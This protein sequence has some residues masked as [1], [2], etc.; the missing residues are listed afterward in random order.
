M[1]VAGLVEYRYEL[2]RGTEVLST[3]QC[4]A[5]DVSD[6]GGDRVGELPTRFSRLGRSVL[7]L[8]AP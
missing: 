2:R 1:L 7:I 3:G 5:A 6:L 8:K 4:K